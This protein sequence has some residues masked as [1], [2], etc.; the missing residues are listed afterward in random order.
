MP[1]GTAEVPVQHNFTGN[2]GGA[3]KWSRGLYQLKTKTPKKIPFFPKYNTQITGWPNLWEKLLLLRGSGVFVWKW[4]VFRKNAF[5]WQIKG[6]SPSEIQPLSRKRKVQWVGDIR[7]WQNLCLACMTAMFPNQQVPEKWHEVSCC[8][9][10]PPLL[11][12]LWWVPG[13][14]QP[15]HAF[16][17][18]PCHT[19][20]FLI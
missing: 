16:N 10:Q 12:M 20:L 6:E 15:Q 18:R 4:S 8:N 1:V 7:G 19:A 9:K 5:K 11:A 2:T 17:Y 14:L 3:T 13:A